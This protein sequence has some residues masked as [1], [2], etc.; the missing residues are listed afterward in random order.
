MPVITCPHCRQGSDFKITARAQKELDPNILC[1]VGACRLCS[2]EVWF[3]LRQENPELVQSHWP[4]AR[5]TAAEELSPDVKRAF[6]EALLCYSA[7]AWNGALCLC[8]RAITDALIELGAPPKGDLPAQLQALVEA[9]K[10]TPALKD[11]ADQADIG[12]K[13]AAPGSGA[14][15]W[16]QPE[17]DWA[18]QDDANEVIDFCKSFFEYAYVMQARLARRRNPA[19]T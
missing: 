10:I 7:G 5:E 16:G 15:E 4:Q 6:N 17:K 11:W 12:G 18:E 3:E 13:L 14:D 9:D 2:Q 1:A 8:R 19:D